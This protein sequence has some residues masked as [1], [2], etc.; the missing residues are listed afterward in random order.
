MSQQH[1]AGH[2]ARVHPVTPLSTQ[3]LRGPAFPWKFL[4]CPTRR[5]GPAPHPAPSA[6]LEAQ[7]APRARAGSHP[8]ARVRVYLQGHQ[9][10]PPSPG[11]PTQAGPQPL[12]LL[13]CSLL[14]VL[15]ATPAL[16]PLAVSRRL[17]QSPGRGRMLLPTA[18]GETEAQR[19]LD[20]LGSRPRP[21]GLPYHTLLPCEVP[22]L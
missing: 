5:S 7:T 22:G 14:P 20:S 12:P 6:A 21:P 8:Q 1:G 19:R 18:Q 2:T 4:H 16:L 10:P 3:T 17:A 15:Q 9:L 13:H 11:S